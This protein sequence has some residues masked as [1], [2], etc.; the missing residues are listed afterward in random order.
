MSMAH[1]VP[2]SWP[3]AVVSGNPAYNRIIGWP[4]TYGYR[5]H[6]VEREASGEQRLAAFYHAP[7][8]VWSRGTSVTPRPSAISATGGGA[9]DERN[10]GH[11]ALRALRASRVIGEALFPWQYRGYQL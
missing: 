4:R 7:Q 10:A 5:R 1:I 3:S 9:V 8:N 6:G 11:R 2:M